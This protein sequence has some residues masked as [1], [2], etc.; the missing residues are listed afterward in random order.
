MNDR[1]VLEFLIKPWREANE[2]QHRSNC[3][4]EQ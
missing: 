2:H 1:D 4:V 3:P